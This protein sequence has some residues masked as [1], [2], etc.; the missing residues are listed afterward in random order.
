MEKK[1]GGRS[2]NMLNGS[3]PSGCLT[4]FLNHILCSVFL[5]G[6]K[7][8][9]KRSNRSDAS[10]LYFMKWCV[11][12]LASHFFKKKCC[13]TPCGYSEP[14]S[15]SEQ[16]L[17]NIIKKTKCVNNVSLMKKDGESVHHCVAFIIICGI[18]CGQW[19]VRLLNPFFSAYAFTLHFLLTRSTPSKKQTNIQFK[20]RD[21]ILFTVRPSS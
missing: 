12:Y 21:P 19:E 3:H 5:R 15:K 18:V 20:G 16:P 4:I 2:I 13:S 9:S 10:L 17:E 11:I 6:C 1:L 7:F 14:F 8:Y